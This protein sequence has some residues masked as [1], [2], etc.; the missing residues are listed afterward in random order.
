MYILFGSLTDSLKISLPLIYYRGVL[1]ISFHNLFGDK[2]EIYEQWNSE[3]AGTQRVLEFREYWNS[4][5]GP[6]ESPLS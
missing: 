5:K 4:E 2:K 1:L 6:W 3:S